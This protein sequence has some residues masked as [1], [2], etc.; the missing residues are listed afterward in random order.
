MT[1]VG[2]V[3][4]ALKT[5]WSATFDP[6]V[7]QVTYGNRVTV[8]SPARLS[9][10]DAEGDTTAES[11]GPQRTV[12]ENYDVRCVLSVSSSGGVDDQQRVTEQLLTLFDAA[13]YAIRASPSQTLGVPGVLWVMVLGSWGLTEAPASDTKGAINASF[14]F[15]VHVR[16]RYQLS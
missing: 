3:R 8:S 9:I 12:E 2:T 10:G 1:T 14:E 6:A 7:L 15:R 13:E 5:L 11:L 4:A 16:A